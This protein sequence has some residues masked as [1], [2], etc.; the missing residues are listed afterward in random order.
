MRGETMKIKDTLKR[1][2][3]LALTI[4][5]AALLCLAGCSDGPDDPVGAE[6]GSVSAIPALA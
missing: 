4:A 2:S 1:I 5:L 3:T 6:S